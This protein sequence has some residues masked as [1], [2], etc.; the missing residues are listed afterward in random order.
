M[1]KQ[2]TSATQS[3]TKKHA[4]R[5]QADTEVSASRRR[6]RVPK[7]PATF[8]TV[9]ASEAQVAAGGSSPAQPKRNTKQDHLAALLLRDE[10]ATIAQMADATGWLPHTVR[11]ALTGLKK[12]GYSIDSDKVADVR[13]YRATAPQ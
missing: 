2:T 1:A 8:A 9:A 6:K 10:G 12:K 3:H 11:A 7:N 4:N 13:S 5:R